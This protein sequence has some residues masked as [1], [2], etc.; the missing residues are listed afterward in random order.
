MRRREFI[1]LLGA[2]AAAWP[3]AARAQQQAM[4]VIG[5]LS[6][7]SAQEL[8]PLVASFHRG[9]SE[10]GYFEGRNVAV[11]YRWANGRYDRLPA[12]AAD[13][14]RRQVNVIAALGSAAPAL[15]AKAASSVIPIVFQTGSDPV[16]DGLVAS[17]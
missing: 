12:L 3:V 15:A 14:V 11:E 5:Y 9:L 17:M 7:G 8:A 1:T 2:A 13:L 4:P 16:E 6:G 10:I